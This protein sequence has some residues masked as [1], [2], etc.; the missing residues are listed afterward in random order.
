MVVH[1]RTFSVRVVIALASAASLAGCSLHETTPMPDESSAE[2]SVEVSADA[3]PEAAASEAAP[4]GEATA[5]EPAATE[6][7][8][9]PRVELIR[10]GVP[11]T[12]TSISSTPPI[13][14]SSA[15]GDAA[16]PEAVPPAAQAEWRRWTLGRI[17]LRGPWSAIVGPHEGEDPVESV[18][19]AEFRTGTQGWVEATAGTLAAL[20][21]EGLTRARLSQWR[22]GEEQPPRLVI[23]LT[24]G[25]VRIRPLANHET[26]KA[27]DVLVRTPAGDVVVREQVEVA[28]D[29]AGGVRT[30]LP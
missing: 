14:P 10:E 30:R 3:A 2:A 21:L 22:L 4:T 7:D 18:Q 17:E 28:Y 9:P 5:N 27:A 8:S 12:I 26:G 16:A 24:R 1:A 19:I 11:L 6:P 20:R 13:P 15:T 29:A 23:E 25:R